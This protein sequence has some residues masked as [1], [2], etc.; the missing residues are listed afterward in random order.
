MHFDFPLLLG[1]L[2]MILILIGFFGVQTHTMNQDDLSYDILNFL[3]S[4]L[5]VSYGVA[6]HAWPFVIL[7]GVWALYSLKDILNDTLY[8]KR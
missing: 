3:G 8:K 4:A 6:G 5:L 2:G 1:I 7:N